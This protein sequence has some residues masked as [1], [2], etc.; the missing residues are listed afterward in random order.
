MDIVFP[1]QGIWRYCRH[2]RTIRN[3]C[4]N[5]P[6]K[7]RYGKMGI[8]YP[9]FRGVRKS[10][11]PSAMAHL[12]LVALLF[13]FLSTYLFCA[14][15]V[16]CGTYQDGPTQ[17]LFPYNSLLLDTAST[18]AAYASSITFQGLRYQIASNGQVQV[19]L[20]K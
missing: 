1:Y 5:L 3:I 2:K 9:S 11:T 12:Q 14:S 16:N 20:Q 6:A 13:V 18:T 15:A 17:L 4:R 19:F 8:I 10:C 7:R